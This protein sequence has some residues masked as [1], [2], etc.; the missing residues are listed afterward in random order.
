LARSW[1]T[2]ADI[3]ATSLP[4]PCRS[5]HPYGR[6]R[7]VRN[8]TVPAPESHRGVYPTVPGG[9]RAGVARLPGRRACRGGARAGRRS[10]QP[11]APQSAPGLRCVASAGVLTGAKAGRMRGGPGGRHR[12]RRADSGGCAAYLWCGCLCHVVLAA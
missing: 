9:A 11:P 1:L 3:V 8:T 4:G 10:Q 12:R 5:R 2:M 6:N 7:A